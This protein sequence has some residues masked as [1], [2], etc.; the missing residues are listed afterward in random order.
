MVRGTQKVTLWINAVNLVLDY[1]LIFGIFGFQ[2]LGILGAG[3]A[4]TL[5]RMIGV[6]LLIIAINKGKSGLKFS[7]KSSWSLDRKMFKNITQI[8]YPA[9]LERL[10]MRVGQLVYSSMIIAMGT[11]VY[12]AHNIAGVIESFSYMLGFGFAIAASTL[13]GQNLGVKKPELAERYAVLS[14]FLG[15]IFMIFVGII[16]FIFARPLGL[17]FT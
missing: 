6:F 12:A 9:G 7:L 5:S 4:T 15:T 13:V 11:K 1:I 16:F 3:I 10:V 8:G 17:L 2:G 14:N